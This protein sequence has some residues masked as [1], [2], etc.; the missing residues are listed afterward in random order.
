MGNRA[1]VV[2]ESCNARSPAIYLHWNGG[3]FLQAFKGYGADRHIPGY[4]C[5]HF[6]QLAGNTLGNDKHFL[7]ETDDAL[8]V[9]V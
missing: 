4:S 3:P 7:L 2:S 9:T 1:Y 6:A 5:A 8:G